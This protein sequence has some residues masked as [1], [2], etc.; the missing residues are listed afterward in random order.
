MKS[1]GQKSPSPFA[2]AIPLALAIAAMPLTAATAQASDYPPV[3]DDVTL[4]LAEEGWV[5]TDTAR[6]VIR[7]EAA[8]E[9]TDAAA[10]RN[11]FLAVLTQLDDEADWRFLSYDRRRDDTG[12]ERWTARA[13][14]RLPE[15]GL[16]GLADQAD[17]ASRPGLAVRVETTDFSPTLADREATIATLRQ[18]IYARAGEELAQINAAFPDRQFRIAG[19]DFEFGDYRP[20]VMERAAQPMQA[21]DSG[22]G[23]AE[24]PSVAV[25]ERI[26]VRARVR[27]SAFAA[28]DTE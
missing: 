8:G 21:M 23:R 14:A 6:V 28:T 18:D 12:L 17:D 15:T 7:L 9:G 26:E 3:M 24:A 13:E 5:E 25:A 27:L 19:I 1:A 11:D 20:M 22:A 10:M 16:D 2:I 4:S